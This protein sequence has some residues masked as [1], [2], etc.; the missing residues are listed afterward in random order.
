MNT[1]FSRGKTA[2]IEWMNSAAGCLHSGRSVELFAEDVVAGEYIFGLEGFISN[3]EDVGWT[4]TQIE[5]FAR[6]LQEACE[7][8][9]S[10]PHPEYLSEARIDDFVEEFKQAAGYKGAH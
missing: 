8:A 4:N 7:L 9:N 6:Q 2:V 10:D 5:A 1:T 3:V